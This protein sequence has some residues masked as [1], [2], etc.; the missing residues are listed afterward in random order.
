MLKALEDNLLGSLPE[1]LRHLR[2]SLGAQ[3]F[4]VDDLP[5]SLVKHW[6]ADDGRYRIEIYPRENLNDGEALRRFVASVQRVA[7]DAIGYPVMIQEGGDAVVRAFQQALVL[8]VCAITAL[9]LVLMRRKSDVLRVLLPLLLAGAL[10][11]AA[12]VLLDIPFN[13]ANVIALP[14]LLGIGVDSAI[15]MVHR[16]RTAPPADGNLLQSST[17]RAVIFSTLTT[18]C[19]FGNLA[20]SPHRGMA[21]MGEL[22]SIGIGFTLLC[23]LV[24]LPA[25][26][27]GAAASE[28]H[29][30]H[31]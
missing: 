30:I 20:F 7:P 22:L 14:L 1:G 24:L 11:G 10:T 6:V 9:L 2:A 26:L 4:S 13:F 18:V 27:D 5:R 17:A 25:L 29:R 28:S 31:T 15:H 21:S 19:S 3:R 23:T 12:S 16:M 8:A